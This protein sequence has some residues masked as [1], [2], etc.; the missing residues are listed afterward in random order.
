MNTLQDHPGAIRCN[1]SDLISVLMPLY[2]AAFSLERCL[3]SILSQ[4]YPHF[5]LI[6]VNDGS[7]DTT[8]EILSKFALQD[9]RIKGEEFPSNKGIVKA[10]N[11]GLQF[12]RGKWIA[13]M[14]ADDRMHPERLKKQLA[15][16]EDNPEV[17]ILGTKIRLFRYDG[18]P[19]PG[20]INYQDWSNGLLSDLQ[21]KNNIYAESPI[22]H[23]TFFL[24]KELLT[25]LKEYQECPWP[26]DYDL[27]FKAYIKGKKFA[28]LDEILIEK[29]DH[30]ARLAR[31]DNRCKRDAMFL[32][33]AHYF[34][35]DKKWQHKKKRIIVGTGSAAK[36][37][38][39]ALD[40][41]GVSIEGFIGH[42]T[43]S[44]GRQMLGKSLFV[45]SNNNSEDLFQTFNG[46]LLLLC[47]G[48][49]EDRTKVEKLFQSKGL[50]EGEDYIRF[51]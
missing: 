24:R 43:K 44:A 16:M 15:F 41:K 23:P 10:L 47:I 35:Q 8:K 18:E 37:A 22:M 31:T 26:E 6:A 50:T 39:K 17:D 51:I 5:E 1:V 34:S 49:K 46:A 29:G 30:P 45:L 27:I 20:Q 13:R 21:I 36:M 28:K 42:Q 25:E 48:V 9:S 3:Q 14:D 33:K 32:A 12:C 38:F 4:T 7:T 11:H 40:E 2:N 19:S